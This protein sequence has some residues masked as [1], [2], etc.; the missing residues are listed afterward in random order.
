MSNINIYIKK[1]LFYNKLKI[2]DLVTIKYIL[3]KSKYIIIINMNNH[4]K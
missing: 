3:N 4:Y 1:D 2:Y